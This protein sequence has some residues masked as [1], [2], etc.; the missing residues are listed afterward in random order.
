MIKK[1]K[2]TQATKHSKTPNIRKQAL[3]NETVLE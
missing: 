1:T 2:R 3:I